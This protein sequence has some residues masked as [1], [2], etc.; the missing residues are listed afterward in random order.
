VTD[1]RAPA[2]TAEEQEDAA[3]ATITRLEEQLR[4]IPKVRRFEHGVLRYQLGL[5]YQELPVGERSINLSRAVASLEKAAALFDPRTQGTEHGR[6][7]NA[8]GAALREL[9]QREEAVAA[10]RR[11]VELLPATATPGEHGAALNNLGLA[12]SDLNRREEAIDAFEE[13]LAAFSAPGLVRQRLAALHNLGQ[14]LAA[15]DE[16]AAVARA[17]ERFREA[18]DLADPDEHPYQWA[19]IN[20]SMGVAF[21]A[22]SEPAHAAESFTQALR[23]FTRNRFPFQHA[24]AKNNLGLAHAQAGD[25]AS[26]RR[27]VVAFEDALQVLDVRTQ[28]E[29]W[30]QAYNNLQLAERALE[31][32]GEAGSRTQHFVR[33][34]AEESGAALVAVLRDRLAD[35]T[36]LPEPRRTQV[37][38]EL[39]VAVLGLPDDEAAR[40]TSAWLNI[41][42]ELPHEQFAA[43]LRARIE[44][45]GLLDAQAEARARRI[46]DHA[47][48]NELL[49]PQRIRV[50]DTLYEMGYERPSDDHSDT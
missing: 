10:F 11:A 34:A 6:T 50:R 24:L 26:L 9:G 28:R 37:L 49:A 38:A 47:V 5:A 3:K 35:Y 39:D 23:V 14:A 45:H 17:V 7:Q 13:A 46:L 43:G 18:L 16:P 8:L 25:V 32:R 21:T 2:A 15:D 29:Q 36:T 41:L 1:P 12:L 33:V 42:M 44:V 40:L 20:H 19:L 31:E 4:K 22:I 30:E 48:Q 27:A